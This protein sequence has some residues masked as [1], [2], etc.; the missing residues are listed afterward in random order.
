MAH[1]GI[2]ASVQPLFITSD[3]WA[4]DRLGA[5]RASDLYPLKSML[6][7]GLVVSGSSDSPVES[8]SPV[9]GMWA[10]MVRGGIA[11]D[12]SLTPAEALGLYTSNSAYNGFDETYSTLVEGGRADMTLFDSDVEG[13]HPALFRKVGIAATI[14]DGSAIHSFGGA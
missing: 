2:S 14:V 6:D 10:S 12:E 4:A 8:M 13:M 3:T 5:E 7:E 9:L 11:P 1:H